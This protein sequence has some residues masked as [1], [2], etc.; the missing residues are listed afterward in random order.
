MTNAAQ[1]TY[2]NTGRRKVYWGLFK[3]IDAEQS[4]DTNGNYVL[5]NTKF[6]ELVAQ[7]LGRRV[8]KGEAGRPKKEE[9]MCS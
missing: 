3:M 6:Q 9:G 7:A 8:T 4:I 5:G 2:L 1:G